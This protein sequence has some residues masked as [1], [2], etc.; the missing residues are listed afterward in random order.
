MSRKAP[1]TITHRPSYAQRARLW[2]TALLVL[3][4]TW[5][6]VADDWPQWRGPNRD[7][8]S[9]ETGLLS[10]W[11]DGGPPL[12]W[13]ATG[14]G[15]GYSSVAVVGDR[16]YTLGDIGEDQFALAIEVGTGKTLWKQ[17]VGPGWEDQYLG[18]RSTPTVDGEHVYVLSTEGEL[19]CLEAATGKPVWKR[20]LRREFDARLMQAMGQYDWKFSESPLVDGTRVVVTPGG[21]KTAMV[22]LDK[23]TGEELWRA[24]LPAD[25]E[26]PGVAGAGYSSAVVAQSRGVR[27]YVQ[28]VGEGLI[29]VDAISGNF[30]W[31]YSRVA[32]KIANIATPLV[33]GNRVFASTGYQ[34]GAALVEVETREGGLAAKEVYFL[35]SEVFQ[36]HHGGMILDEGHVYTGTGHNKGFPLAV[37]LDDGKVV[38]GP[39]RTQGK[40]SA[41][42]AYADDHLYLRYQNGLMVLAEATPEEYREKGSFMIPKVE[43][44]SWSHPV[45]AHGHLFLKEQDTLYV[46]DLRAKE[47]EAKESAK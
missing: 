31:G 6:V 21:A 11:P 22:A 38:W 44:E 33:A 1:A 13:Q 23:A 8:R 26:T 29:S 5:P 14:V 20:D 37:K 45:I 15:N 39:I 2:V 18:S 27:Q 3:G 42:I 10:S 12:A 19:H 28:M 30:L 47:A 32:N 40:G 17:R 46:Y 9:A 25:F 24:A 41:A 36:N 35:P 7:G 34:T 16:V 4:V 43:H